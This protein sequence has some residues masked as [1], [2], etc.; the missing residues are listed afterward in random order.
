MELS[1]LECSPIDTLPIT[2]ADGAT[3][4]LGPVTEGATPSTATNRVDGTNFSVYFATSILDP[5][6]SSFALDNRR[7]EKRELHH[8]EDTS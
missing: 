4:L 8:S 3:K 5:M 2:E 6:A 7:K 1:Y